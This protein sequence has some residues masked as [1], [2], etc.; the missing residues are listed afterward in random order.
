MYCYHRDNAQKGKK[1]LPGK[2]Q[3]GSEKRQ[4]RDKRR[5]EENS[6][7]ERIDISKWNFKAIKREH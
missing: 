2:C 3:N 4:S 7:R 1:T 6:G 5:R